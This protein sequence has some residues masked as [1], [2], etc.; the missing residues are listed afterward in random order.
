MSLSD[1]SYGISTTS[2]TTLVFSDTL[3]ILLNEEDIQYESIALFLSDTNQSCAK[4]AKYFTIDFNTQTIRLQAYKLSDSVYL[5][6]DS[7]DVHTIKNTRN[8]FHTRDLISRLQHMHVT[9]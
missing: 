3:S 2:F 7:G 9:H 5:Y 1:A 6:H 4:L 8:A